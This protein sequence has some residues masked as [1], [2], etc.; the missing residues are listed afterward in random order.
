[1]NPGRIIFCCCFYLMVLF[2]HAQQNIKLISVSHNQKD[3]PGNEYLLSKLKPIRENFKRINSI[4]KWSSVVTKDNNESTEGGEVKFYYLNG[5]LQKVIARQFGETFQNLNE[6]YLLDGK[7][8][9]VLEKSY[10]YN[11]PIYYDSTVMKENKDTETFNFNKSE[12]IE[13]RSYFQ[14]G[15]MIHQISNQD[16]G[17]PFADE[18]LL[19][20]EKR[21]KTEYAKLLKSRIK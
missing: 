12:I 16:C 10:K 5:S 18:Y 17:A 2:S 3:L 11:R 14:N 20:E 9:F 15:K 4:R 7:L 21:I 19:Q 8:S 6:Y 1:M 13:D